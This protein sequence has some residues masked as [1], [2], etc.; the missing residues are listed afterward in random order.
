M[1]YVDRDTV[2]K[3]YLGIAV[4]KTGDDA[5]LDRLCSVAQAAVDRYCGRTFEAAADTTR[6]FD[7]V[8]DTSDLTLWLRH[9]LAQITSITNGD[10]T[11]VLS[12]QY[13]TEPRNTTPYYAVRIK[14]N[15]SV[16]W[17]LTTNGISE[18]AITVVGRWAYSTTAPDDIVQATA[19]YAA[20]MYRQKDAQVFDTTA[21]PTTGQLIIPKGM[22]ADVKVM[23][24]PY[25][26]RSL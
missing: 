20:Y 4:N 15:S 5:L 6:Y 11:T 10:G 14:A 9:D 22:P 24:E 19:R 8:R 3:P 25:R 16:Y 26:R 2:L 18:D 1:A 17:W 23:L 21:D 12:S 13:V 7:A